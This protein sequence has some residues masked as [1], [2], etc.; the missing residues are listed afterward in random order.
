MLRYFNPQ[1]ITQAQ[2]RAVEI[3][4]WTTVE[5][6][7]TLLVQPWHEAEV[8]THGILSRD[9]SYDDVC[10]KIGFTPNIVG[11]TTNDVWCFKV[12]RHICTI[13][14]KEGQ[15]D[16][17]YHGNEDVLMAIFGS[18]NIIQGYDY[19]EWLSTLKFK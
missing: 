6:R 13:F 12:G 1:T 14:R 19:S 10:E 9:L 11:Y 4:E 7:E 18:A 16:F 17:R 15:S 5:I 3:R 8:N 2:M